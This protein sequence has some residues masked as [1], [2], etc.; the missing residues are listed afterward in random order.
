M[1]LSLIQEPLSYQVGANSL[2]DPDIQ[3]LET[4]FGF[5][6]SF[7]A[8]TSKTIT[9]TALVDVYLSG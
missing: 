2:Y 1:I 4:C 3:S 5:E 7:A 9:S 8:V 6:D